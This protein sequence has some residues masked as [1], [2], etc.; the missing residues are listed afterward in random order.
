[1]KRKLFTGI[2]LAVLSVYGNAA[3]AELVSGVVIDQCT[4]SQHQMDVEMHFNNDTSPIDRGGADVTIPLNEI[5]PV[6]ALGGGLWGA[7][8][9]KDA[10]RKASRK[11]VEEMLALGKDRLAEIACRA[12][13]GINDG[14]RTSE[15][16][17]SYG[18]RNIIPAVV[19]VKAVRASG[20]HGSENNATAESID[21]KQV[22]CQRF[23]NMTH[24]GYPIYYGSD[25]TLL[26]SSDLCYIRKTWQQYIDQALSRSSY[27]AEFDYQR[28]VEMVKKCHVS[29]HA[30]CQSRGHSTFAV[31]V[32]EENL[33][34]GERARG[35]YWNNDASAFLESPY[36]CDN[37]NCKKFRHVYCAD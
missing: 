35:A 18:G 7:L 29:A 11:A 37:T 21:G 17:F 13:T 2:S 30:F 36:V 3:Y 6:T 16:S 26:E 15:Y 10:C 5:A 28:D 8:A 33:E 20:W 27:Y 12:R 34:A 25:N 14:G 24:Y 32:G 4:S 31:L 9:R 23:M 19:T 1:M 22:N